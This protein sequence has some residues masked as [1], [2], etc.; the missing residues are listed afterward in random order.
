MISLADICVLNIM[1][2]HVLVS[3][4]MLFLQISS[5]LAMLKDSKEDK[6]RLTLIDDLI[7]KLAL[8]AK[9]H[10]RQTYV[11]SNKN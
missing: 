7:D 3:S 9:W 1:W 2:R 11:H 8:G 6:Q 4:C 10:A 5:I